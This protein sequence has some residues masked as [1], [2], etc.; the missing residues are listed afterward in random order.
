M[1]NR[2]N[3]FFGAVLAVSL[4]AAP[5]LVLAKELVAGLVGPIT[6][7]Q[8]Q[9]LSKFAERVSA[10]SNGELTV[11]IFPDGQLGGNS[12]AFE[13]IQDGQ[14]DL[15]P[16]TPGNMAEFVPQIQ[17]LVV[18]FV[19]RDFAHWKAVTSGPVAKQ[20]SDQAADKAGVMILGYFGGSVRNLVSRKPIVSLDDM[21]YLRIR[22]H[23]SEVQ[24]KAWS[25]LGILPT[26]ISYGEIYNALQ[27][28]VIDGLENEPEWVL[29]MKFYEQAKTY[30]LTEHEIVTRPLIFSKKTFDSLTPAQ[31]SAVLD[32]GAEAA[33]FQHNL[34]HK[35]DA[36]SRAQ[37]A[38]SHGVTLVN[39]D[40]DKMRSLVDE[41][42]K[43]V[44]EKQGL[45]QI[46]EQIASTR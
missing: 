16:M 42:L 40:K 31:R 25:A 6:T 32:A 7:A 45:N 22:L 39:I 28:D 9:G 37:L 46:V 34:E 3:R 12:D 5:P 18:P 23:P 8:G 10:L 35:L 13:L 29:R 14:M 1:R 21:K 33:E 20:L 30:A 2:K 15:F 26:V 41:A 43:P 17:A 19:F 44:I 38:N 24:I 36:E 4:L 11:K 27:L